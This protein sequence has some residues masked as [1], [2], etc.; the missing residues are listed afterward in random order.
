M[1]AVGGVLAGIQLFQHGLDFHVRKTLIGPDG[2]MTGHELDAVVNR[3]F[4][5]VC[6]AVLDPLFH[7]LHHQGFDFMLSQNSR[8]RRDG[9]GVTPKGFDLEAQGR[10]L[11]EKSVQNLCL[12]VV[13]VNGFGYQQSL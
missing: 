6:G 10:K 1:G 5:N 8:H 13:Q 2:A 4:G 3:F 7:H 9:K 12:P 11:G